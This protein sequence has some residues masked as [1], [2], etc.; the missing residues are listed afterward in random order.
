M[1]NGLVGRGI[2]S[3]EEEAVSGLGPRGI[4]E[5][6]EEGDLRGEE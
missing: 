4:V 2:C 1:I 5:G 6:K 3:T